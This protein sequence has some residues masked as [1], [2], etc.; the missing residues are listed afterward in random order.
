MKNNSLKE[1]SLGTLVAPSMNSKY[2]KKIPLLTGTNFKAEQ[3]GRRN[4]GV[5]GGGWGVGGGGGAEIPRYFPLGNFWRLIWKNE[6]RK[7]VKKWK[8]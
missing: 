8:M 6:A 3:A 2:C 1:H 4:S 7:N 5:T